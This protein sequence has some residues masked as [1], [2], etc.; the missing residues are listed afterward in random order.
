MF[1]QK[2][3]RPSELI[4]TAS[5]PVRLKHAGPVDYY[6]GTLPQQAS[7]RY[8]L[9]ATSKAMSRTSRF[10]ETFARARKRHEDVSTTVSDGSGGGGQYNSKRAARNTANTALKG[11]LKARHLQMIAIGGSIGTGLFIGTGKA[12]ATAGSASVLLA[13]ELVGVLVYITMQ[14]L[15]ELVSG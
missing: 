14:C 12:L 15:A 10:L 5:T 13:F 11:I 8:P 2:N 3:G 4:N 7:K 1:D 6:L 9:E